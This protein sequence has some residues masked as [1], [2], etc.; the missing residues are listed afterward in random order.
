MNSRWLNSLR[1][2][3]EVSRFEQFVVVTHTRLSIQSNQS[4]M[5]LELCS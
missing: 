2:L 5:E 1:R 4:K 3:E